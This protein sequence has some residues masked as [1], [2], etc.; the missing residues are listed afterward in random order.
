MYD[1]Q[2]YYG[3]GKAVAM[4]DMKTYEEVEGEFHL[5]LTCVLVELSSQIFF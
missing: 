4:H 3:K 2:E 5:F 1:R